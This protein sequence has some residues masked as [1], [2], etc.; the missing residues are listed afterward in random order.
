MPVRLS[1]K[2]KCPKNKVINP[3]TGRCVKKSGRIGQLIVKKSRNIKKSL[4]K[5]IKKQRV[6]KQKKQKSRRQKGGEL[7][8][9]PGVE[10]KITFMPYLVDSDGDEKKI[11]FN[12]DIV[13]DWW[14]EWLCGLALVHSV[15]EFY[16]YNNYDSVII[17]I[18]FTENGLDWTEN[19]G[20]Q[21]FLNPEPDS[22]VID[23]YYVRVRNMNIMENP[24]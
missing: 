17:N 5:N 6:S 22:L 9:V 20:L 19:G 8:I 10:Y 7:E 4:G 2:K 21:D 23:G 16:V 15:T 11:D 18:M 12:L 24:F 1:N 3:K 14:D 13:V